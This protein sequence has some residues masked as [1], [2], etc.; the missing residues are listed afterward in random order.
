M[1]GLC[2]Q[3]KQRQRGRMTPAYIYQEV[4]TPGREKSP[5][6][7][8][9]VSQ[10]I[11]GTRTSAD[12]LAVNKFRWGIRRSEQRWGW[13][14]CPQ[15]KWGTCH[16][17][18]FLLERR[19]MK[20]VTQSKGKGRPWRPLLVPCSWESIESSRSVLPSRR[21]SNFGRQVGSVT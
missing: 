4:K 18:A 7:L 10:V 8:N 1:L 14:S 15:K 21:N 16:L 11:I 3:A 17:T 20:G 12:K 2:N 6:G 5:I 19:P 9:H 13:D